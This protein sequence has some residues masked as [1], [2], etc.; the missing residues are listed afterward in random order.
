MKDRLLQF[1]RSQSLALTAG[2]YVSTDHINLL[3]LRDIGQGNPLFVEVTV[4]EAF[5]SASSAAD[6]RVEAVLYAVAPGDTTDVVIGGTYLRYKHL[7]LASIEGPLKLGATHAFSL[8]RLVEG[9]KIATVA[10]IGA[11][12]PAYQ[13]LGVRYTLTQTFTTGKVTTGIIDRPPAGFPQSYAAGAV[14]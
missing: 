8:D 7:P 10:D 3:T 13:F 11:Y 1:S 5:A 14:R 2:T 4:D 6:L 9:D 12:F